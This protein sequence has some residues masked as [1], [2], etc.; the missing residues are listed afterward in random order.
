M[1]TNI[2]NNVT[3]SPTATS[4][5]VNPASTITRL[6]TN[7]F[8]EWKELRN[9]YIGGSDAASVAGMNPYKGAITLWAEKTGR[10]Q[11]FDGNITTETGTY[12][13]PFVARLFCRETGKKVQRVNFTLVNSA[14]P[15][16]C[17]NV[18]RRIVGEN[19]LLECKTTNS[20]LN[21][22]LFKQGEYPDAWYCQMVHYMAVTGC[23]RVYLAVLIA[24]REFRCFVLDRDEAEIASLMQLERA[25]WDHVL[26]GTQPEATTAPS[27]TDTITQLSGNEPNIS[28]LDMTPDI[29]LLRQYEIKAQEAK[30]ANDELAALKNQLCATL[31]AHEE[32][33]AEG[34]RVRWSFVT[35]SRFNAKQ[36]KA[37]NPAIDLSPYYSSTTSRRFDFSHTGN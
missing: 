2:T 19:A 27:D 9:H 33:Y 29:S 22:K 36:F 21:L 14:Y 5:N 35:T 25:F 37:A 24:C 13:E 10:I 11:P 20:S 8:E 6:K 3:S 7:S 26:N 31:G 18:D 17:A 1:K 23:E 32:G 34:Y 4:A 12:L 16:A 30:A 15:F 28:P